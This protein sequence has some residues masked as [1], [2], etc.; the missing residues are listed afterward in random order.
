MPCDLEDTCSKNANCSWLEMEASY[1]CQCNPGFTGDGYTC[2]EEIASCIN[3]SI[4]VN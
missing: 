1:V 3:V 2:V 4:I